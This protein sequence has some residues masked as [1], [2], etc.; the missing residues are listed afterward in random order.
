MA[1]PQRVSHPSMTGELRNG[2]KVILLD[3]EVETW[4]PDRAFINARAA[5]VGPSRAATDVPLLFDTITIQLSGLD[6]FAG[7]GPL[8]SFT[9]P[10]DVSSVR[11]AERPASVL[12][13]AT[14]QRP[15]RRFDAA[16]SPQFTGRIR[17]PQ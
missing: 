13:S 11:H 1:F 6:A 12:A 3:A 10:A 9:Y 2:P 5:L 4:H 8:K 14:P 7:I 17:S 16:S 15:R